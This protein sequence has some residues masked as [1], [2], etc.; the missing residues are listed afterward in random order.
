VLL[1]SSGI[2][3]KLLAY[4]TDFMYGFRH[5]SVISGLLIPPILGLA[6]LGLDSILRLNILRWSLNIPGKSGKR[7]ISI[8]FLFLLVIIPFFFSIRSAYNFSHPWYTTVSVPHDQYRLIQY[9]KLDQTEWVKTPFG[10]HIWLIP[11]L[12][13]DIKI[14]EA[15]RDWNWKEREDPPPYL[16][17][18]E[19][20]VG[21][22]PLH[23]VK[24]AENVFLISSYASEY[25][26]IASNEGDASCDAHA[27]GGHIDVEC[28]APHEGVLTVME[29]SWPGWTVK[30]DGVSGSLIENQ[31]WLT[32]KVE[33]GQ[34]NYVFN[35]LPLDVLIGFILTLVGIAIALFIMIKRS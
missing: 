22:E 12:E 34:H 17:I 18:A 2:T 21:M 32:V 13:K 23:P 1:A 20:T 8:N 15:F 29:N 4:I 30:I 5:P 11:A 31:R 35:Y 19:N 16:E 9:L 7:L 3:F 6:A 28:N 25:A 14:G 33:P 10:S 27:S 24:I 26:F